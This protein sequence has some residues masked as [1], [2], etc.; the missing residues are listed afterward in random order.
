MT[1]M[2]LSI[3]ERMLSDIKLAEITQENIEK[4]KDEKE[5]KREK[6]P[7]PSDERV[8]E[9]PQETDRGTGSDLSVL[10]KKDKNASTASRRRKP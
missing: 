8:E 9:L 5:G 10:S 4:E 7:V 6:K 1:T 3:L 2:P